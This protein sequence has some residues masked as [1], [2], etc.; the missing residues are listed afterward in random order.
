MR[1]SEFVMVQEGFAKATEWTDRAGRIHNIVSYFEEQWMKECPEWH[2]GEHNMHK[3][4]GMRLPTTPETTS[5]V[6]ATTLILH[7]SPLG[8]RCVSASLKAASL[9]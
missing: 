7:I 8:M 3:D 1:K 5:P 2:L 6:C 4:D 9:Q